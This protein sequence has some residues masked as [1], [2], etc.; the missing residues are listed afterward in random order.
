MMVE[1]AKIMIEKQALPSIRESIH[2][3]RQVFE[4][5]LE[6]H[7]RKLGHFEDS[8]N[9]TTDTFLRLFHQG[10]LDDRKEWIQWEHVANV[11]AL[12]TR[13]LHD[14]DMLQYDA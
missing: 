4:K 3:G 10:E 12:L 2:I 9:M 14:L 7:Q 11:V 1:Y 13:K 5:K 8:G 6:A